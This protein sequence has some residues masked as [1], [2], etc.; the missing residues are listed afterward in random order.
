M[1]PLDYWPDW[2]LK[3][4]P[5]LASVFLA[6]SRLD[7]QVEGLLGRLVDVGIR[8]TTELLKVAPVF[9]FAL[10]EAQ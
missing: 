4:S 8:V 9:E 7:D 1:A 2:A 6:R 5:G 10:L 3:R